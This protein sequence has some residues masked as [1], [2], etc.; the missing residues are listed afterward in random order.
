MSTSTDPGQAMRQFAEAL[1]ASTFNSPGPELRFDTRVDVN[2]MNLFASVYGELEFQQFGDPE[3]RE[4]V[5]EAIVRHVYRNAT[6][7]APFPS[8]LASRSG[9]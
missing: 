9:E 5:A 2:L 3:Q 1:G 6:T 4:A 7:P 8:Q